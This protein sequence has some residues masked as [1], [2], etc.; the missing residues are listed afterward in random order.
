MT[1]RAL[2]LGLPLAALLL[3]ACAWFTPGPRVEPALQRQL[4]GHFARGARALQANDVDGAIAAW[5]E[6][7]RIA[8]PQQAR[9]RQVRGYLTLLE[10]E[11]ASRFARRAARLE[12]TQRPAPASRF[13][14]A[15]LPVAPPGAEAAA[16]APF[17][18]AL[19][20]MVT[21]DLARVPALTVLEREK[22][23]ALMREQR[24]SAS[25]L[26]DPATLADQG[27]L[28]GAGTVVTGAVANEPGP[29]GPGSGRYRISTAVA[30]VGA[31]RQV[32]AQQAEGLQSEFF[33]LQKRIVYGILQALDINDLPPGVHRI[34][35][36]N[37]LAYAA[38]ARGLKLLDDNRFDEARAAFRSAL[39]HDPAFE[40]AA[41]AL[42]DVPEKPATLA[43]IQAA[44]RE[45]R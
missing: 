21:T 4:D 15:L 29:A 25:G 8:P 37:W 12:Q 24:L 20:A 5:R 44:V 40:L 34:H 1:T 35:T 22:I 18:R 45:A 16:N 23:D 3:G 31:S 2:R 6:Y 33:T 17:N 27:R 38:F 11:S 19:M 42:L 28:L 41:E 9:T 39:G 14:V 43:E 30:D 36:R 26:V 10:R 13:H 7:V 32:A